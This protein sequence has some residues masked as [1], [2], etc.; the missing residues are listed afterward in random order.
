[1]P[2]VD[3]FVAARIGCLSNVVDNVVCTHLRE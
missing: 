1:V 2:P 3:R